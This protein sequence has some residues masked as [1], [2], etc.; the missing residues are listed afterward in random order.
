[1]IFKLIAR[2]ERE[3]GLIRYELAVCVR[4]LC[5]MAIV[6]VPY[7]RRRAP[8]GQVYFMCI[9]ETHTSRSLLKALRFPCKSCFATQLS[10]SRNI[11]A[12]Y[13]DINLIA[14]RSGCQRRPSSLLY[15]S[16]YL[17]SGHLL[18]GLVSLNTEILK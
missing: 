7:I 10:V 11:A 8:R 13:S 17:K 15:H 2:Q 9:G 5:P 16:I 1:M 18:Y 14:M 6:V 3:R 4:V 12:K